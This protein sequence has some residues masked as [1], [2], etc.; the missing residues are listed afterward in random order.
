M[1]AASAFVM[2]ADFILTGS[3]NQCTVEA[4]TSDA[5][6]DL[7]EAINVQ[8]TDYAPAGDMFE[9]GARV[10][11]LKKGVLFPARAN[12]LYQLYNQY[13]CLEEIPE[14]TLAQLERNYFKKTIAEIW[15]E[16]K[17]YFQ[18]IGKSDEI[19][20]AEQTP[21]K[22]MAL[23]FRWYFGYSSRLAFA[24]DLEGKVN[25]QVHTGPALGAF[26]QWVKGTEL[27]SWRHRHVDEIGKKLM[28]DAAIL[29]ENMLERLCSPG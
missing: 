5:V 21:R 23:I 3:I 20:K 4:G 12:K 26:N 7:L 19:M 28:E 24:G 8:D 9:I 13:P 17:L 16:T 18:K 2:G 22:K 1:S 14:K 10:Q 25:F 29:L 11:V 15:E 27:E 6:K